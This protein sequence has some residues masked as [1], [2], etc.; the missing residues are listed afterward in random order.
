MMPKEDEDQA[1]VS[2]DGMTDSIMSDEED[3][4]ELKLMKE[5]KYNEQTQMDAVMTNNSKAGGKSTFEGDDAKTIVMK[6]GDIIEN[7][8]QLS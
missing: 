5:G 8:D 3:R 1:W 7:I 4:L 2:D 6:I